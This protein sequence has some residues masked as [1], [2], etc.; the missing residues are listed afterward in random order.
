M[1]RDIDYSH[2]SDADRQMLVR[3]IVSEATRHDPVNPF[4]PEQLARIRRTM[5]DID[6]GKIVCEPLDTVMAQLRKR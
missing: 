1:D 4:T 3:D 5:A 2:L 6:S